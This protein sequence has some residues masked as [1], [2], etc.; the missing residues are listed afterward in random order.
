M[1]IKD[2]SFLPPLWHLFCIPICTSSPLVMSPS[3]ITSQHLYSKTYCR[4]QVLHVVHDCV[5]RDVQALLL[6]LL[7]V[8]PSWLTWWTSGHRGSCELMGCFCGLSAF[9]WLTWFSR[10]S[11][12]THILLITSPDA[13][14]RQLLH[15][16]VGVLIFRQEV[17][18][19]D[20]LDPLTHAMMMMN[21][22]LPV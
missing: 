15:Q 22:I 6:L 17:A 4:F 9:S 19:G 1:D 12:S 20:L 18:S 7:L 14:T 8:S 13:L 5:L 2:P 10:R 11:P 16:P 3:A 21:G